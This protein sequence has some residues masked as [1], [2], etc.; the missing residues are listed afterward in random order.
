MSAGDLPEANLFTLKNNS[1]HVSMS[2]FK[3][4]LI[5]IIF[6]LRHCDIN[7]F[8]RFCRRNDYCFLLSA[9]QMRRWVLLRLICMR[10]VTEI[11]K[12]SFSHGSKLVAFEYRKTS[13]MTQSSTDFQRTPVSWIKQGLKFSDMFNCLLVCE[14]FFWVYDTTLK[15]F[16]QHKE[17]EKLSKAIRSTPW[18]KLIDLYF[19][20]LTQ[21]N[22]WNS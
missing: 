4:T 3:I 18:N 17:E 1:K 9:L 12:I 6:R 5:I 21:A 11:L 19:T 13:R 16:Q 14:P 20:E 10:I 7:W 2:Y 15:N 22:A 8:V